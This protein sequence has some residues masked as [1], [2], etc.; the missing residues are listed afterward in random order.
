L[1]SPTD[2][3]TVPATQRPALEL[4]KSASP[5]TYNTTGQTINYSYVLK[6]AGNVALPGPFTVSDDKATVTC[7]T[8][9][10][11]ASGASITCSASYTIT[12]TDLDNG[13]ETSTTTAAGSGVTPTTTTD[14]KTVYLG[15]PT[16]VTVSYVQAPVLSTGE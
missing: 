6:N 16:T 12:Q 7:P 11:L 13:S 2:T 14:T 4:T 8:T 5:A 9:T 15:N 10:S 1:S 3:V